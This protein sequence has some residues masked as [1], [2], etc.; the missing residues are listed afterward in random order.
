MYLVPSSVHCVGQDTGCAAGCGH[1]RWCMA[2]APESGPGGG[3]GP[4]RPARC[5]A[6]PD[7][8]CAEPGTAGPG[9]SVRFRRCGASCRAGEG[10][11]LQTRRQP[12]RLRSRKRLVQGPEG[13][14]VEIVGHQDHPVGLGV[15]FLQPVPHPVRPVDPGAPGMGLP[16][17]LSRQRFPSRLMAA[18][19]QRTYVCKLQPEQNQ[20]D[21]QQGQTVGAGTTA[22][23]PP[24]PLVPYASFLPLLWLA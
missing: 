12:S 13:V 2:N 1:P 20:P 9:R 10:A 15:A 22:A 23:F 17:L 6:S 21:L 4:R 11:D 8:G 3:R 18:G 7:P 5:V 24:D 16:M 19:P 14:G